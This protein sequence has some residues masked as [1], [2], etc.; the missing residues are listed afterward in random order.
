[1]ELAIYTFV[2][3][4]VGL[5]SGIGI[6]KPDQSSE[7][8]VHAKDVGGK[9][10][11]YEIGWDLERDTSYRA[12]CQA[13]RCSWETFEYIGWVNPPGLVSYRRDTQVRRGQ[14]STVEGVELGSQL[15]SVGFGEW[16]KVG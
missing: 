10:R 14:V 4:A 9:L 5:V 7:L 16:R 11:T 3:F 2:V 13:D 6:G 15:Q 8:P 1:M 12:T